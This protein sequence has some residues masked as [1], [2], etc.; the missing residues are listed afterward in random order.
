MRTNGLYLTV[1]T[2]RQ[3][4]HMAPRDGAAAQTKTILFISDAPVSHFNLKMSVGKPK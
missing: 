3:V 4:D 2:G 1:D